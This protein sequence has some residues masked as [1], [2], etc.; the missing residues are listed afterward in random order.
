[1]VWTRSASNLKSILKSSPHFPLQPAPDVV[2]CKHSKRIQHAHN[3]K[4]MPF[5]LWITFTHWEMTFTRDMFSLK[6]TPVG[7][8]TSSS[9]PNQ[10]LNLLWN[11]EFPNSHPWALY[12]YMQIVH[13]FIHDRV[14]RGL[15]R[16]RATSTPPPKKS[17]LFM[18]IWHCTHSTCFWCRTQMPNQIHVPFSSIWQAQIFHF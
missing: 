7:K 1:M 18:I 11:F 10:Q 12:P 3:Q 16:V 15:Y 6:I 14:V 13:Q 4:N 8:T 2:V 17:I 5:I 9:S